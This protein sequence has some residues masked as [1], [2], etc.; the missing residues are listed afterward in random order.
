[1]TTS[2]PLEDTPKPLGLPDIDNEVIVKNVV[3]HPN[4]AFCFPTSGIGE[5]NMG[6]KLDLTI[7]YETDRRRISELQLLI[8][9]CREKEARLF[10]QLEEKQKQQQQLQNN[11]SRNWRKINNNN[12]SGIPIPKQ[13]QRET[14]CDEEE[15]QYQNYDV[16][17]STKKK[18]QLKPETDEPYRQQQNLGIKQSY[19]IPESQPIKICIK[20]NINDMVSKI[21]CTLPHIIYEYLVHQLQVFS[22]LSGCNKFAQPQNVITI[23]VSSSTYLDH[24]FV[25]HRNTKKIWAMFYQMILFLTEINVN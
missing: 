24:T 11:S 19:L 3:S 13:R 7:D 21:Y 12:S 20:Y 25:V 14:K 4:Q 8:A 6:K 9:E 23:V 18:R 17:E 10:Q 16:T 5:E 1:M 22:Y 2:K 15:K